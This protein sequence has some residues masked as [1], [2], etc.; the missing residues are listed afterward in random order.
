MGILIAAFLALATMALH[1][2]TAEMDEDHQTIYRCGRLAP[3]GDGPATSSQP[4][5]LR[6]FWLASPDP[7]FAQGSASAAWNDDFLFVTATL[8]DR[9]I[10][11]ALR[12]WN[13][14]FYL[15]GDIFE[16]LIRPLDGVAY[17]EFH[18]TPHGDV[19][20]LRYPGPSAIADF[21]ESGGKPEDLIKT[22][23]IEERLVE[24]R[25]EIHAGKNFW[26]A[27]VKIPASLL[28]KD[29]KFR[30]GD[31]L[32]VSFCRYDHTRGQPA[33]VLCSTSDHR[34]CSFHR[35]AEWRMAVLE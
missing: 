33:P 1:G 6:Q 14:P 19:L 15:A 31:K 24:A 35:Q 26:T 23:R 27:H 5:P 2:G 22:F 9:D 16:I 21:R 10:F 28:A 30:R 34:V 18:V 13:E 3:G 8:E 4:L 29:G 32:L 25:T 11:N 17:Y 12:G 7:R 20:Q